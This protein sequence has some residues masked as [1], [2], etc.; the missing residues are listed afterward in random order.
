MRNISNI[1]TKT[2]EFVIKLRV[3]SWTVSILAELG[4]KEHAIATILLSPINK[5]LPNNFAAADLLL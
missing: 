5:V 4:G 3:Q 1:Y 2:C